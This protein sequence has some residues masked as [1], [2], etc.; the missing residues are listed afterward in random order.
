MIRAVLVDASPDAKIVFANGSSTYANDF[1]DDVIDALHDEAPG[2]ACFDED[3]IRS[4]LAN[5]L[6]GESDED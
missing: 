3:T 5:L 4:V 6:E 2:R 1:I